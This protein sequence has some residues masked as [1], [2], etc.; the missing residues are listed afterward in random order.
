V[1]CEPP[2]QPGARV[3]KFQAVLTHTKTAE[4][5]RNRNLCEILFPKR[6]AFVVSYADV[7]LGGLPGYGS[8]LRRDERPDESHDGQF[9]IWISATGGLLTGVLLLAK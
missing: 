8:G 2:V 5:N 1:V 9:Q 3:F 6:A 4:H 7:C